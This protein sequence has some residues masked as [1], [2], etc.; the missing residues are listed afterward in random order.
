LFI[1]TTG[2]WMW[3][4]PLGEHVTSVGIIRLEDRGASSEEARAQAFDAAVANNHQLQAVLGRNARR[5]TPVRNVR[6]WSYR[7]SKVCGPG[8][9][10]A[11]D[12]SAFIDPVLSTGVFLAM[13]AGRQAG[14]LAIELARGLCT[15]TDA[16]AQYQ[17]QHA[18]L[19][20]DLLRIVKFFYQQNLHRDDYFWESKR[21][22]VESTPS[23]SPQKS[24]MI[25][26]SGL[27][28]N[29]AYADKVQA[30]T[31]RRE[32]VAQGSAPELG[33]GDPDC[34]RFLCVHLRHRPSASIPSSLYL[35]IEPID[36]SAPTLFRTTNWHVN[37]ITPRYGNDPISVPALTP[38][39]R[40]LDALV[41]RLD[42]H[43][44]ESLAA[45]W[46]R[47][48]NE[49]VEGIRGLPAEFELVRIFGE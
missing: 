19:F 34:L 20:D 32:L 11:G 26:T 3:H 9:M 31:E 45:F 28:K 7:V 23:I 16:L 27:V 39:L 44:G 21:I 42:S 41:R 29:L 8:W 46:R 48:R 12:S 24:F 47:T 6:D 33:Q 13:H 35:L 2:Q 14:R 43:K 1:A 5:I 22:L 36:P 38:H 25:L 30:T 40:Q 49:L 18:A 4:F 17:R 37:C 15:E 10:L